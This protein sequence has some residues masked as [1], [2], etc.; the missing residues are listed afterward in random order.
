MI[1]ERRAKDRR[2][3][4]FGR[5]IR[6]WAPLAT[7]CLVAML[8]GIAPRAHAATPVRAPH[9][10]PSAAPAESPAEAYA[11]LV[12]SLRELDAAHAG[13]SP[14]SDIRRSGSYSAGSVA[15]LAQATEIVRE[16]SRLTPQL[17]RRELDHSQGFSLLLPHLGE[18]RAVAR[19]MS[20]VAASAMRSGDRA[21]L[22]TMLD[23]QRDAVADSASDDI[24]ISSL[25]S[26][27]IARST[28]GALREA[29]AEGLVDAATAQVALDATESLA[30]AETYR[31]ADAVALEGTMFLGEMGKLQAMSPEARAA[32]MAQM[33]GGEGEALD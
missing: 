27:S 4:A 13:A 15:Y 17:P 18:T 11:R 23:A 22:S 30:S 21:L 28:S 25:V 26:M 31:L 19:A 10:P 3:F 6:L 7:A 32:Q 2:W 8:G 29:L 24:L 33:T 12:R 9:E 20:E 5:D 1:G 14:R 16:I